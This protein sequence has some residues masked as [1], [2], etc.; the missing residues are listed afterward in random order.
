M[1]D[2]AR[3]VVYYRLPRARGDAPQ[4]DRLA[5]QKASVAAFLDKRVHLLVGEFTEATAG[6]PAAADMRAFRLAVECCRASGA[7]LVAPLYEGDLDGAARTAAREAAV[8][9]LLIGAG[10]QPTEEAPYLPLRGTRS[11]PVAPR[12]VPPAG[13]RAKADAFA[14]ANRP[15]IEQIRRDGATTL[16]DISN[17]L[18]AREVR[19]ARGRRW[20]PTTVRNILN[21]VPRPEPEKDA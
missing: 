10:S 9:V 17:A 1:D 19:T 12:P 13:N 21:R 6:A 14:R 4:G 3:Y 15:I 2:V 16:T 8:E 18:N 20:H 7:T 11:L 5:H